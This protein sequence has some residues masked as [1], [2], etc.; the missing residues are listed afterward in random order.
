M[1][2]MKFALALAATLGVGAALSM[3][4]QAADLGGSK[5]G[6]SPYVDANG[7]VVYSLVTVSGGEITNGAWESY[8]GAYFSFNRDFNRDGFFGRIYG[9]YGS[10][11]DS[12]RLEFEDEGMGRL[13]VDGDYWTGDLM[14]GYMWVRGGLDIAVMF[15]GEYQK[16]KATAIFYPDE[17]VPFGLGA[18]GTDN[19]WGFKVGASIET[20]GNDN[21]PIYFALEGTYSTAFESYYALGRLGYD[22]GRFTFGPEVWALGDDSGDAQRVGGFMKVEIPFGTTY[23]TVIGSAGYQFSNESFAGEFGAKGAYATVELRTAFG[24]S[25]APLK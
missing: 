21:R 2:K 8:S 25:R 12:T 14:L 20:N 18:R 10:Y 9:S 13:R 4:A 19:E 1:P 16:R 23:S 7:D 24:E 3:P 22:F 11:E 5:G 6:Y 17:E 15:G